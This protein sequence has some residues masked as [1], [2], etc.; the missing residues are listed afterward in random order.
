[1]EMGGNEQVSVYAGSVV[2]NV[3]MPATSVSGLVDKVNNGSLNQIGG[4]DS[5]IASDR[6]RSGGMQ[7]AAWNELH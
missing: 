7:V 1:M 3:V 5:G 6:L 4:T 2:L